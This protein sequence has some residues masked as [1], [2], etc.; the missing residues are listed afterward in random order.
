MPGTL[1]D[2]FALIDTSAVVALHNPGDRFHE[3]A[4][5]F[6]ENSRDLAWFTL[7]ITAH[8]AF[9]RIRYD[10]DLELACSAFSFLRRSPFRILS[11]DRAD[12]DLA[13]AKARQFHEHRLSFHDVLCTVSMTKAGIFKI[14]TFDRDFWILGCQVLP[15][16]TS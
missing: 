10:V 3:Q 4:R 8:E 7:D 13:A 2:R 16:I 11:S 6:Y 15:G 5:D 12:E 14:F 9:T 1:Y